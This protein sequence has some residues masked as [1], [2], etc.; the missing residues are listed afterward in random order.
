[1]A[2]NGGIKLFGFELRR[3]KDENNKKLLSVVP[4]VDDDGAGYVTAAGS[5]YGQYLNIEGDDSKDNT[6]LVMKYRGVAFQP[7]VD[8]AVEDIINEA[9]S[10]SELKSSVN[11]VL[12]NLPNVSKTIKNQLIEEFNNVTQML[13]FEE[14]GH[15][16]FRRWYVDGRIYYHLVVNE[17]NL[18]AG[19][20]EVRPIDAAKI[21][22]VKQV[23]KKKDPQTGAS[24]VEKTDEYFIFQEKSQTNYSSGVKISPDAICYVTSGLLSE[25]KRRVVSYLHK[26]LKAINQLRMM[27]DSLVIYRL[28]RAPERRIFYI[29]VGNLPRG[30][31]EQYMKDIM[32]RYRNKLVYDAKTGE[33]KDDRK[34]MSMLED[35]WL[36]RRE[37]GR[38][39]EISTLP[40]G[41]NLGQIDDIVY[42][43]KKLYQSLNVP[44]SR[45][46]QEQVSGIL[47][48]A[49]EISRDE[50]KFQKF[51][52]RLRKRF[53][54]VFLEILEK[55][56][57][58]KGITTPEDWKSW[59]NK[60]IVSYVRDNHFTELRD[61]EMLRERIQ[62]LETLKNAELIGTYFSKDWVMKNVL[63]MSD[64]EVEEMDKQIKGEADS[65][66]TEEPD[67]QEESYEEIDDIIEE[68]DPIDEEK[69]L[70]DNKVKEKEL[71][72]LE[73]VAQALAN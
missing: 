65:G 27:E 16:I 54:K 34:H 64:E 50:L 4:K 56:C 46:D 39:T 36:P 55:Q 47:G 40:G 7:E 41:D 43:Q 20:Q 22:K 44:M 24:L 12:D 10:G 61:S 3:V 2:D 13:N 29:D 49:T 71:Q 31:A 48:R 14:L 58:L 23:K 38:G 45:L 62:T 51:I 42:F 33:I 59:K 67:Q 21:R 57:I 73:N 8:M 30:K 35:F 70:L 1:M 28:A 72:V 53:S 66:E 32:T 63:R 18:K 52:D 9:I 19:I 6:Q 69:R 37:G 68:I 17:S 15:D 26:A 25:D 60:I 5:H 11:L